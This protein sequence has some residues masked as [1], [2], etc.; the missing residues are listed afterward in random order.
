MAVPGDTNCQRDWGS[1]PGPA[2]RNLNLQMVEIQC[3]VT[4]SAICGKKTAKGRKVSVEVITHFS[5]FGAIDSLP[6]NGACKP[7]CFTCVWLFETQWT[8]AHQS[9]LSMGF[10]RQEYWNGLQFPT[11]GDLPNPG[12]KSASLMSP[13]LAGGFFT[14]SCIWET[15]PVRGKRLINVLL[16]EDT[17]SSSNVYSGGGVLSVPYQKAKLSKFSHFCS[18]RG[19]GHL[20][21]EQRDSFHSCVTLTPVVC[22]KPFTVPCQVWSFCKPH[23]FFPTAGPLAVTVSSVWFLLS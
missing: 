9:P 10:S 21:P 5:K 15:F 6:M 2:L 4:S 13:S 19:N 20:W 22:Y 12:N 11:P 23:S 3:W 1:S 17:F 14:T 7:S 16:T 18:W 8:V